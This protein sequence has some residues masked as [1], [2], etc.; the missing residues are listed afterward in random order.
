ME[1]H[2]LHRF[3]IY[4]SPQYPGF[5]CW[6]GLWAMPDGSVMCSFTQATGPFAG[7]PRAPAPVRATLAWPPEG[8]GDEYDMTG[9]RLE[10]V[11]LRS[12]DGGRSWNSTGSDAFRSC[13]N[14]A[15]GEA[16]EALADG[17]LLRGV[18]G[19][20]LPYDDVPQDGYMQHSTDAGQS[21]SA[22]E[23]INTDP[24]FAFWPKRIRRLR[25]GRVL[26][27]GGFYRRHPEQDTRPRWTEDFVPALFVSAD[28]RA[29]WRGPI[30]VVPEGQLPSFALTEELDW[31]ELE[32]GSLLVVLRAGVEEGRLQTRL[33][34]RGTGW[35][36]TGV[37]RAGLPYSGHP[38]V[39]R[40]RQGW[41]LH[42][43]TTGI[44][45]TRDR[46]RTWEEVRLDDGLAALRAGPAT[47]YYPRA[48]ELPAGQVLVVG[49]VGG[50]DGYGCVDQSIIGMRFTLE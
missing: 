21:W 11:H 4:H 1:A 29:P 50:D 24:Q 40:T 16:E 46:G 7:R 47:P 25:D 22:P 44:S 36:T 15:T 43:A 18:W 39:L 5:T 17:T 33:L 26:T 34:P 20:Y 37:V 19:R 9:L 48:V 41:V 3:F 42:V 49:H 31:A 38:E 6:C 13:M 10:N 28:G 45:V 35:Q 2:D 27:G 12:S 32:D 23:L 14:G 8:H 30:P